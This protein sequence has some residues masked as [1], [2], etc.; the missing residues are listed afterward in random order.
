MKSTKTSALLLNRFKIVKSTLILTLTR[1]GSVL[2][3]KRAGP[4]LF[5]H[6]RLTRLLD[7]VATRGMRLNGISKWRFLFSLGLHSFKGS[8]QRLSG[9]QKTCEVQHPA[10][11]QYRTL[12]RLF[13]TV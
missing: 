7:H 1:A 9:V 8:H 10:E 12:V 5:G 6:P 2:G 3:A 11:M 13:F 4:G